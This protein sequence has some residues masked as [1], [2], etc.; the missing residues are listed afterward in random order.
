MPT[1]GGYHDDGVGWDG[2]WVITEVGDGMMHG[3]CGRRLPVVMMVLLVMVDAREDESG[4]P[5]I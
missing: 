2:V 3:W 5:T 4:A 1:V